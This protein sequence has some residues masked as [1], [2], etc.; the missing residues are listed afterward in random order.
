MRGVHA[1]VQEKL[2]SGFDR[3]GRFV[4]HRPVSVCT[5]GLIFC[6]AFCSGLLFIT[7]EARSY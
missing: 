3:W 4:T 1:V 5:V 7:P 2:S 6:L